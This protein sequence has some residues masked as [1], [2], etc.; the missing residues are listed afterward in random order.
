M[1][2]KDVLLIIIPILSG[3]IGSYITYYLTNKSKKDEAIFKYKEEKY[4]KLLILF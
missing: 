3:V 2:I 4:S 1:N